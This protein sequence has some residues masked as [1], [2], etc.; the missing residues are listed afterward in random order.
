MTKTKR[1]RGG[2]R[3]DEEEEEEAEGGWE[4]RGDWEGEGTLQSGFVEVNY[5]KK[6]VST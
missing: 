6:K 2:N 4:E 3:G 5:I 1:R